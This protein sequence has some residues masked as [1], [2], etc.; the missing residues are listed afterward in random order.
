MVVCSHSLRAEPR[1]VSCA[2]VML[3]SQREA[4]VL[5]PAIVDVPSIDRRSWPTWKRKPTGHTWY[6]HTWV[7]R[8]TCVMCVPCAKCI[9][10][11]AQCEYEW[12]KQSSE[13]SKIRDHTMRAH[14]IHRRICVHIILMLRGYVFEY[15]LSERARINPLYLVRRAIS[16]EHLFA[17]MPGWFIRLVSHETPQPPQPSLA[18]FPMYFC[19]FQS[20]YICKG[21]TEKTKKTTQSNGTPMPL[22]SILYMVYIVWFICRRN[23]QTG[24]RR[25]DNDAS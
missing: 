1:H 4:C 2:I 17:R 7:C 6:I 8:L 20:A 18:E 13:R 5:F 12:K 14:N 15:L 23:H 19:R 10:M 24:C 11:K 3:C 16:C 22:G 9:S 25:D 21:T